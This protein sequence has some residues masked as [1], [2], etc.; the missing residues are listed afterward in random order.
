LVLA[1]LVQRPQ[2]ASMIGQ[3]LI[4][5]ILEFL[6]A[7]L[8]RQVELGRLRPHDTRAAA[9]A[10]IGMLIPQA[11]GMVFLEALRADGLTNE[12]HI[13]TVVEIF[14]TGLQPKRD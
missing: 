14:L 11:V 9:R 4:T 2:V 1:E 8:A 13:G 7:Y 10:F 5:R 6:K 3:R 12:E